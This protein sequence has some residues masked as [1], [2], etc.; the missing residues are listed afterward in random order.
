MS[1]NDPTIQAPARSR[2][3]SVILPCPSTQVPC[4]TSPMSFLLLSVLLT[5]PIFP[6]PLLL[7][8]LEPRHLSMDYCN[9]S[10]LPN[11][12]VSTLLKYKLFHSAL[13]LTDALMACQ[14]LRVKYDSFPGHGSQVCLGPR[15][16]PGAPLSLSPC[17]RAQVTSDVS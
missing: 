9:H 4:P 3:S 16:C 6:F 8:Y 11:I 2:D 10:L 1:L 12:S 17:P 13:R 14:C 7:L 5:L 15:C